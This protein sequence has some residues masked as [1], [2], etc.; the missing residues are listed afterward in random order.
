MSSSSF[1]VVCKDFLHIVSSHLQ[2]VAALLLPFQCGFLLFLFLVWLLCTKD[3][4][5]TKGSLH[6]WE[7]EYK[8]HH[9]DVCIRRGR[10][11]PRGS[12][13]LHLSRQRRPSGSEPEVWSETTCPQIA[14]SLEPA[15]WPWARHLTSVPASHAKSLQS[16]PTLCDPI[17]GSLPGSPIRGI[18]QARVLEW[19]ATKL[20]K[21]D[22]LVAETELNLNTSGK[23]QIS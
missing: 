1:L 13:Q 8:C 7:R 4:N 11:S 3:I 14:T 16:C 6:T 17:D 23:S 2:T 19:V 12:S 15:V 21:S 5:G 9:R 22:L 20:Y 18:C 10:G